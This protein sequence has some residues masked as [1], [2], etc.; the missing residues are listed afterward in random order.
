L[1]DVESTAKA[2]ETESKNKPTIWEQ[3]KNAAKNII[4]GIK[5]IGK[6]EYEKRRK[7]VD[8]IEFND[9]PSDKEGEIILKKDGKN[10]GSMDLHYG[11]DGLLHI[12]WVKINKDF[13]GKGLSL[14]LYGKATEIA[15]QK[16]LK[17][18]GTGF[19]THYFRSLPQS[20]SRWK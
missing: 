11:A 10:I 17:G 7:L 19:V 14:L 4:E 6:S 3:V 20:K 18:V 8:D 16:G 13:Q 5:N 2:L 12:K 1:R 9:Y 15:A